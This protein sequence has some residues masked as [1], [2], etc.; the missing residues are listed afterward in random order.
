MPWPSASLGGKRTRSSASHAQ[1]CTWWSSC[2]DSACKTV[3]FWYWL[4]GLL[5]KGYG[6]G[7]RCCKPRCICTC[8]RDGWL[9]CMFMMLMPL[10]CAVLC[11]AV[12]CCAVLCC[13]VLSCPVLIS[14]KDI[15]VW[16]RCVSWRFYA[17]NSTYLV[18]GE[19]ICTSVCLSVCLYI[20]LADL[21]ALSCRWSGCEDP[22]S[23]SQVGRRQQRY[24]TP[25]WAGHP[26]GHP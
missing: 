13:A 11:H 21:V 12:L 24:R 6:D 7:V 19:S 14:V 20:C 3:G 15:K 17:P 9:H 18:L 2:Y 4:C 10:W 8:R 25:P 26:P 5:G 16:A 1:V 22:A 23:H